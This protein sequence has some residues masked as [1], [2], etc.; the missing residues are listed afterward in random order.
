MSTS[1][2]YHLPEVQYSKIVVRKKITYKISVRAPKSCTSPIT[3]VLSIKIIGILRNTSSIR[4]I[5]GKTLILF[6]DR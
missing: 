5:V 3:L 6:F 1:Y 4:E 2:I